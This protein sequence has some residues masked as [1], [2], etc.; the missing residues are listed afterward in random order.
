MILNPRSKLLLFQTESWDDE[1]L[2]NNYI[3]GAHR[4]FV[5]QYNN[6]SSVNVNKS[7]SINLTNNEKREATDDTEFLAMLTERSAQTSSQ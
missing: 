2:A 4:R 3:N 5:N 7:V 1:D 6:S